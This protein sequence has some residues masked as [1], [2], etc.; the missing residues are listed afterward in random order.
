MAIPFL[1]SH[2]ARVALVVGV[3]VAVVVG[4][5]LAAFAARENLEDS[6]ADLAEAQADR[7]GLRRQLAVTHRDLD[8]QT[9]ARDLLRIQLRRV[10]R[11]ILANR[12]NLG[13]TRRKSAS[14]YTRIPVL[15]ECLT[16]VASAL[17]AAS[18]GDEH[19][20]LLAVLSIEPTC[21]RARGQ[22]P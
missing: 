6:R 12:G 15:T 5:A 7:R 14:R 8:D 13:N 17:N 9:F 21:A 20:T 18:V 11:E 4:G 19:T 3:I 1:R 22:A 2:P 16:G 10:E